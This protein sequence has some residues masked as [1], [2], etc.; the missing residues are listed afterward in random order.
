MLLGPGL[1]HSGL[2]I[3]IRYLFNM[4][5]AGNSDKEKTVEAA[6]HGIA[7]LRADDGKVTYL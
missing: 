7:L 2:K 6:I 5:N 4:K 1:L 3:F